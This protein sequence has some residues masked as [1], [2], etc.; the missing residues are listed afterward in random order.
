MITKQI[1]VQYRD[2]QQEIKEIE[3]SI[4]KLK[5]EIP[6]LE[7]R[8]AEI[9]A[10]ETVKDKVRG[11]AGGIQNFAIEG[12]PTREYA[13]RKNT[14]ACKKLLLD[15]RKTTL[16][17]QNVK[18]LEII[19]EIEQFITTIEDSHIRRIVRLRFVDNLSW[20]QVAMRIGGNTEDS[21]RMAFERFIKQN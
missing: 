2:L 3:Q 6:K 1:L 7:Q 10:G 12:I 4:S 21:V 15:R 20:N 19:N 5:I 17:C 18:L 16:E 8:L 9:E 13:Q 11:G 14:L